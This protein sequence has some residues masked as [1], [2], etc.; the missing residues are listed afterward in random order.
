MS[1][2]SFSVLS[3]LFFGNY[4]VKIYV[5]AKQKGGARLLGL[6]KSIY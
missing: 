4:F 6:A 2:D 1:E 3:F 5:A